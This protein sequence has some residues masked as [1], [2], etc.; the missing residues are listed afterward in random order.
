[1]SNKQWI[2]PVAIV[3]G[4]ALIFGVVGWGLGADPV[5]MCIFVGWGAITGLAV[6]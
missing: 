3:F 6:C 2:R 1:M 4:S 5:W